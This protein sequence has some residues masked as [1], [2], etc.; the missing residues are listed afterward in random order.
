LIAGANVSF[1]DKLDCMAYPPESSRQ[2][3]ERAGLESGGFEEV[4]QNE[5]LG[6]RD[7][8]PDTQIQSLYEASDSKA[9]QQVRS[10]NSGGVCGKIRKACRK[11]DVR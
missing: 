11:K 3:Q 10:A 5:W 6:G 7:L 1:V 9:D 2:P 8:N 4:R